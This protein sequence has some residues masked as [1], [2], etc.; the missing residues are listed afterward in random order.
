MMANQHQF[1]DGHCTSM[2][3]M[4]IDLACRLTCQ[5]YHP[6][7]P[8]VVHPLHPP[9]SPFLLRAR[10]WPQ[11]QSRPHLGLT[12]DVLSVQVWLRASAPWGG[13]QMHNSVPSQT[14]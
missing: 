3:Y 10:A 11:S 9:G 12:V 1:N 13:K 6:R 2:K 14:H 8:A 7:S 5:S 4:K